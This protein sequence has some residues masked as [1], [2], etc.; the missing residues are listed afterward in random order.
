MNINLPRML[1]IITLLCSATFSQ[2]EEGRHSMTF[3]VGV[4]QMSDTSQF[5]QGVNFE[6]EPTTV[7]V[8]SLDYEWLQVNGFSFG[9]GTLAHTTDVISGSPNNQVDVFHVAGIVRK[10]FKIKDDFQPYLGLGYGFAVSSGVGSGLSFLQNVHVLAGLK[11]KFNKTIYKIEYR[12]II[13]D[14]P[15]EDLLSLNGHS[16]LIGFT[17]KL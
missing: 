7:Q 11:M 15:N 1:I 9:V 8:F 6:I 5:I 12:N 3:K 10:Y 13:A 17:I 4:V 14:N 16:L 2:A